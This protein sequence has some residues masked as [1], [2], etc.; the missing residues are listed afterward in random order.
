MQRIDAK[1]GCTC[2]SRFNF[3]H[4]LFAYEYHSTG[5]QDGKHT[6]TR[7]EQ[8]YHKAYLEFLTFETLA[9]NSPFDSLRGRF[10]ISDTLQAFHIFFELRTEFFPLS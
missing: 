8:S 9:K 2:T 6:H 7:V 3:S 1:I 10:L 4:L 5:F